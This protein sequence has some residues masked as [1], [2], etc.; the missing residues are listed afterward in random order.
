MCC[1]NRAHRFIRHAN[2]PVCS[3]VLSAQDT[4]VHWRHS[5]HQGSRRLWDCFVVLLVEAPSSGGRKGLQ[6]EAARCYCAIVG[7][8]HPPIT[9]A[10]MFGANWHW[11]EGWIASLG[12]SKALACNVCG[13]YREQSRVLSNSNTQTKDRYQEHNYEEHEYDSTFIFHSVL[14]LYRRQKGHSIYKCTP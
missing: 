10:W 12:V 7:Y 3:G 2:T 11:F 9:E 13:G 5:M 4:A 1:A 6:R 14:K 8:C